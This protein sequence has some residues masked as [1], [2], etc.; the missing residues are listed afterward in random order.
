MSATASQNACYAA[1][2]NRGALQPQTRQAPTRDYYVLTDASTPLYTKLDSSAPAVLYP[3]GSMIYNR[4]GTKF[5]FVGVAVDGI[6]NKFTATSIQVTGTVSVCEDI[7]T[8]KTNCIGKSLTL[9][10]VG[11]C[12]GRETVDEKLNSGEPAEWTRVSLTRHVY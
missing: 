3:A 5:N 6:S 8:Y 1:I 4:E 11:F 9:K 7:S 2:Y 10:G 12:I